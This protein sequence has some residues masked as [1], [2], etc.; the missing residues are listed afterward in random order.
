M[1]K[2]LTLILLMTVGTYAQSKADS[3]ELKRLENQYTS[4]YKL[5]KS[6]D[7]LQIKRLGQL[8]MIDKMYKTKLMQIRQD[9]TW[10]RK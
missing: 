9:T 2:F 5:Y 1:V 10:K 8:E 3:L 7:S 6:T 4:I